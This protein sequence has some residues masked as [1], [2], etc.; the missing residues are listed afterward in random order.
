MT[1]ISIEKLAAELQG[2]GPGPVVLLDVRREQARNG[3]GLDIP[4]AIWCDPARWLDWK[5]GFAQVPR[6][7]LYCAHGHE[8]SQG[9]AAA[10]RAMGVDAVSLEGGFAAWQSAGQPVRS[11][12]QP[13]AQGTKWVTRE[14][15]KIDRIACPWL[16]SRFIDPLAEFLY[17]PASQVLAVATQTG[18]IPYDIPGVD[19]SHV[20]D[21]CSFD[22]FLSRYHLS[23]PALQQLA[24]IVRGA[25]TA[26][27]DL[28]PQSA[29]LYALSLGLSHTCPNDQDMLKHG[30]VMYDALY[31]WCQKGQG[32][33][34]NWPPGA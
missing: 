14:R 8:I 30:L 25:D 16:V 19:L 9:L 11:V 20:G 2:P 13:H 18:A 32:E 31:A 3:T 10:L 26:R 12:G 33:T 22:A 4:G 34:H 7:L 29:G 28:A 23:D 5:D 15:P 1:S 21:L 24:T 27:L 17:V 6:V